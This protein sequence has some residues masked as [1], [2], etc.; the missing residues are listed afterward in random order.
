MYVN[1]ISIVKCVCE[2]VLV[3]KNPPT[4]ARDK[5]REFQSFCLESPMDR[6]AWWATATVHR[7]AKSRTP[8][9]RLS[10]HAQPIA[11]TCMCTRLA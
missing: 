2:V 10:A 11:H 3:V 4:Y 9:K 1:F 6:G 8:L 7:I 5:R